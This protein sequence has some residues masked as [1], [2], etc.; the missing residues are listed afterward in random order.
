MVSILL[1]IIFFALLYPLSLK[2]QFD[3]LERDIR[4]KNLSENQKDIYIKMMESNL[5]Y[6]VR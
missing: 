4:E 2:K 5:I 3:K 6:S 1:T